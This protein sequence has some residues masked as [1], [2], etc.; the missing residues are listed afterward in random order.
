MCMFI[1][2][3]PD[4]ID[5]VRSIPLHVIQCTHRWCHMCRSSELFNQEPYF[6]FLATCFWNATSPAAGLLA[7]PSQDPAMSNAN[8]HIALA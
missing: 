8:M 7:E 1:V 3:L 5:I 4:L 2:V 6:E